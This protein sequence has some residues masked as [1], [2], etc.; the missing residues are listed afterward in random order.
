MG[1]VS[2]FWVV[3]T[4][5]FFFFFHRLGFWREGFPP[6]LLAPALFGDLLF[7]LLALISFVSSRQKCK[8]PDTTM[9]SAAS[10]IN[11]SVD[12]LSLVVK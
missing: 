6:F 7:A 8:F 5:F 4:F 11:E 12:N 2:W 1:L 3:F 9:V 10:N